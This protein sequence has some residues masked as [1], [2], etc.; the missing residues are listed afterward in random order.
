MQGTKQ[1]SYQL[2]KLLFIRLLKK[3]AKALKR[4]VSIQPLFASDFFRC[5]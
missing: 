5:C 2:L 4:T 3:I 1:I